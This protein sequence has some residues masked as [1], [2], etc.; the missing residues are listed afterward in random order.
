MIRWLE[1]TILLEGAKLLVGVGLLN[2][3]VLDLKLTRLNCTFV[4]AL[5]TA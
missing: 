1:G 2:G 4:V 3:I 5:P